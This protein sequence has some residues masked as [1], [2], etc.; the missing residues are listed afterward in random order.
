MAQAGQVLALVHAGRADEAR[1]AATAL[2]SQ[3]RAQAPAEEHLTFLSRYA[4]ALMHMNDASDL[5]TAGD[6][7][8]E[9]AP[10]IESTDGPAQAEALAA[11]A[12][13]LLRSGEPTRALADAQAAARLADDD[14]DPQLKARVLNPLGL[15]LGMTRSAA[16]GA[17]ILEQAAEHALAA[18]L[19]A[20]AGRAYTNLSFLGTLQGDPARALGPRRTAEASGTRWQ[21]WPTCTSGAGNWRPAAD[22]WKATSFWHQRASRPPGS[23]SYGDCCWRR[24]G[25]RPKRCRCIARQRRSTIRSRSTARRAWPARQWRQETWSPHGQRSH[26]DRLVQRWP[27]SEALREEARGWVAA[28]KNRTHDAIEH[29]RAAAASSGRAYDAIRLRFHAAHLTGGRQ[30]LRDAIDAFDDMGAAHAADRARALAISLD[31]RP[32]RRRAAAGLVSA[33]EQEVAHLVAAAN[34]NAEI[35]AALD[36]SPPTVKRHF[37]NILTRLGFRSRVQ[38]AGEAPAGR[39]PAP[40][41]QPPSASARL[42]SWV[43]PYGAAPR[44]TPRR[45]RSR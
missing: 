7:L 11:R 45:R 15:I 44:G 25:H 26:I 9:A 28:T 12:W 37:G 43:W 10:L 32:G 36:L 17:A 6:A 42:G 23:Q 24:R 16:Q 29:F 31:M 13:M 2:R 20:E 27:E 3:L 19:R 34:T 39:L 22:C 40:E 21:V 14:H 33:R 30:Q 8:A 41:R 38:I 4:M 35:A 5:Q 1:V 18:N